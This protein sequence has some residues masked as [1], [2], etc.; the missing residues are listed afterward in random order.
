MKYEKIVSLKEVL[1]RNV[2]ASIVEHC[3]IMRRRHKCAISSVTTGS[4]E[5]TLEMKV[6][7]R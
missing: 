5:K 7:V 3:G 4:E 6:K 2:I 1:K